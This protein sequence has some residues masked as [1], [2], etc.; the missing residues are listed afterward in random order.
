MFFSKRESISSNLAED[1][2]SSLNLSIFFLSP[3]GSTYWF[4]N[5]LKPISSTHSLQIYCFGL[6]RPKSIRPL[7]LGLRAGPYNIYFLLITIKFTT[8]K[9][10][11]KVIK[12]KWKKKKKKWNQTS[13]NNR[14]LE[15][16][17]V[18]KRSK[19]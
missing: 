18:I 10:T 14:Y 13:I 9:G 1:D 15:N 16:K 5:S 11:Y 4:T 8:S 7:G 17:N 3:I 19:K 6:L 2:F 12:N